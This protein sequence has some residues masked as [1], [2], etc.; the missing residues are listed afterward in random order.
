MAAN[1]LP[2]FT[3]V[4]NC[5]GVAISA[6]NTSRD[7]GGVLVT[8]FT[9]ATNGSLISKITFTS[10]QATAASSALRVMRIFVTDT[11]GA[12]PMLRGEVLLPLI[13]ASNTVIGAAA[14]FTFTDGLVLKSGQIVKVSQSIYGSVADQTHVIAEGGDY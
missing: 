2:I 4:P 3:L 7:G 14:T 11:V 5:P 9:A 1:V 8:L 13:V 10:A 12:N 6:A